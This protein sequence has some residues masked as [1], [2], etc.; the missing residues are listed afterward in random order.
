[1]LLMKLC[2]RDTSAGEK[3]FFWLRSSAMF[4]MTDLLTL[5]S[6]CTGGLAL[7]FYSLCNSTFIALNLCLKNIL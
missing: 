1:M 5:I 4:V 3:C 7:W 2:D 6:G